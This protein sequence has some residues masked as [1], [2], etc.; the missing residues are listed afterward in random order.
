MASLQTSGI[1]SGLDVNGLVSQL[2]AAERAPTDQRLARLTNATATTLSALGTLRGA[3]AAVATT[4]RALAGGNDARTV[5][6]SDSGSML[7]TATA[8]APTGTHAVEVR[9]LGSN[10]R[11]ASAV[12]ADGPGAK[13]GS[14][15]LVIAQGSRALRFTTTADTTL[16]GLRD[17]INTARDNPGLRAS[18]LNV[19][20]G[21]RLV[22][23]ATRA[24]VAA[25]LDVRTQNA[26]GPLASWAESLLTVQP[27]RD[28]QVYIDG[29]AVSADGNR[30]ATAL[31]G[32][33]LDVTATTGETP[34]MIAVQDD[35]AGR[36][37][38]FGQ[39]VDAYNAFVLTAQR[40]RSYDPVARSAGPL[41]GDASLRN[42]EATLRRA[43][44]AS[45]PAT[46]GLSFQADGS[47]RRDAGKSAIALADRSVVQN[48]LLGDDGLTTRL[49]SVLDGFAG[50]RGVLANRTDALQV[51]KREL[52]SQGATLDARM[53]LVEKRYRAQFSALDSMLT[54]LQNTSSYIAKQLK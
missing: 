21:T 25:A 13:L 31:E 27:A 14:G 38:R 23:E 49:T 47:L 2:V 6:I 22:L 41:I 51:R 15:T 16:A 54:D 32:V 4:V 1:G 37:T 48:A 36:Q 5:N 18:L 53:A 33:T 39:F 24:G 28:A 19:S 35:A 46:F 43:L 40:L 10:H 20:G 17:A 8:G 52:D 50:S 7:A 45:A 12:F 3:V 9:T 42:L 44:E 26:S 30:V 29:F 34:A 11:L